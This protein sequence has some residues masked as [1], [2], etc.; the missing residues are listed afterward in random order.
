MPGSPYYQ[1]GTVV[2]YYPIVTNKLCS[3]KQVVDK[4][5]EL[6]LDDD[7]VIV[8]FDVSSLYTNVPVNEAIQEAANIMYSG[9]LPPPPVD[10]DTFITLVRTC[11]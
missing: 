7:E 10:K 9:N 3:N 5:K 11:K 2:V 4:I 8:S 1:L 6:T